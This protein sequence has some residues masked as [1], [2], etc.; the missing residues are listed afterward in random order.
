[1]TI[2]ALTGGVAAGKTAVTDVL[3]DRGALIIDADVLARSAVEPGTKAL[4]RIADRFGSDMLK[5]DGSLNRQALGALIFADE[6][7]R[8]DLNDIVHPEVKRLYD[9]AVAEA[10][11][12]HPETVLVYAVPLLAEARQV[13]E[14]DA[15][16]VV[17]APADVRLRRLV[18]HR[19]LSEEEARQRVGAQISDEDR[20][21]LADVV[22]DAS[23]D[24]DDTKRGAEELFDELQRLWPDRLSEL[25][26]RFPRVDS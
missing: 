23:D 17:H 25:S 10:T 18:E 26:K 9:E 5:D 13:S 2:V 15:V 19:G 4:G 21:G 8:H 11:R 22:L 16:V 14:F 20:L 3:R 12:L 7:A 24:V 6:T 1:M